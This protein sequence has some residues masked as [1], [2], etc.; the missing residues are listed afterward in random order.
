MATTELWITSWLDNWALA[1]EEEGAGAWRSGLHEAVHGTSDHVDHEQARA[2]ERASAAV[3]QSSMRNADR[4]RM[5]LACALLGHV[6]VCRQ[7]MKPSAT[8]SRH[9]TEGKELLQAEIERMQ[10]LQ[11]RE[12]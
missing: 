4:V 10:N 6:A 5:A 8:V 12:L 3:I 9:A 7:L 2:V 1:Q 11:S